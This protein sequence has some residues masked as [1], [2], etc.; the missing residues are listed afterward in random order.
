MTTRL[1]LLRATAAVTALCAA[2]PALADVKAGT[3][4]W[5]R[6][7]YS[8][9]IQEWQAP[10][11]RGDPD[12]QFNLAQAYRLGRGVP[13]DLAKA[14]DLYSKAAAQGH[15]QAADNYGLLMFDRGER[16]QAMPYIRA[17]AD[18][19]DPRAQYLLGIAYFNG[20]NAPLDWIRAYAL[21]SL[22]QAAGL[23]QAAGAIAQ[24]DQHIPLAQ[25]QAAAALAPQIAEQAEANR[26]SQVAA[27]DLGSRPASAPIKSVPTASATP[28]PSDVPGADF[29]RAPEARPA[30]A[31]PKPEPAAKPA[32]KPATVGS[33]ALA[34]APAPPKAVAPKPVAAPRAA[35]ASTSGNW[36][37]QLG[38]FGVAANADAAWA[39]ARGRPELAGH[40]RINV[41]TGAVTKLQAGGFAS[42]EAASHACA[43]LSA[44]GLTCLPV[45]D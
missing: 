32:A 12:A 38:A 18:R 26:N 20:D 27:S 44:A 43:A 41:K 45:Q 14:E 5:A 2:G 10:A 9:A 30:V 29:A 28:A 11:Q 25:R 4:A 24:M 37:V 8:A 35:P 22:A 39:R 3:D 40:G 19:G 17:A 6:G 7:D 36:R 13:R 1:I 23:P 16:A 21:M 31:Q 15:L 34:A 33:P 42:R